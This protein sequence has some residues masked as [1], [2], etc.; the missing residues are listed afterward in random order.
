MK[1]DKQIYLPLSERRGELTYTLRND[2]LF[3]IVMESDEKILR[4]LL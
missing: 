1:K 4:A 2:Y 3:K